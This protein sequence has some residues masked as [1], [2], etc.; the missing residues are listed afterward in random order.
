MRLVW[1]C[2]ECGSIDERAWASRPECLCTP[3]RK[4][5]GTTDV[6]HLARD[7]YITFHGRRDVDDADWTMYGARNDGVLE[8]F[9]AAAV[10]AAKLIPYPK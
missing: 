6:E 5:F 2:E 9:R 3:L 8:D 10:K 4:K 7:M 1:Q